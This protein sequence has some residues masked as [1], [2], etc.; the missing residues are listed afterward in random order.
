M[1]GHPTRSSRWVRTYHIYDFVILRPVARNDHKV[2]NSDNTAPHQVLGNY[3]RALL[4]ASDLLVSK[5]T[6]RG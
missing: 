3:S 2:S 6:N 4:S 5:S 1:S